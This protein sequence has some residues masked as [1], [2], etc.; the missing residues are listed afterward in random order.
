L[1]PDEISRIN[2]VGEELIKVFERCE[3]KIGREHLEFVNSG[4]LEA[5][6]SAV[7]AATAKIPDEEVRGRR[8]I[9]ANLSLGL[10]I[11]GSS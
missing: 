8:P 5:M 10:N 2:F 4:S 6:A 11:L 3:E 9:S 7:A 1:Q